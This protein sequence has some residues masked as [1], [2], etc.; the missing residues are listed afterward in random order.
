MRNT[1]AT[2]SLGAIKNN[3]AIV[4]KTCGETVAICAIIKADAYGHGMVKV[5]EALSLSG[6][7]KV[8]YFAVALVSEGVTLRDNGITLP[9][10]VLGSI[11]SSE[12]QIALENDLT[13]TAA[14]FEKLASIAEIGEKIGVIPTVH[15]KIDTGMGRVG[16]HYA[17]VEAFIA[18][19][20]SL[21]KEGKIHC[22]GMYSHFSDSLDEEFTKKQFDR[23]MQVVALAKE[24][25]LNPPLLH[26]CSSRS[27]FLY[28][29]YR[30]SMVRPGIVL[31][32]IEPEYDSSILPKEVI[33][34][35][36]LQTK[37]T[38]FKVV[39][40]GEFVGYGKSYT[41][42]ESRERII[43]LPLGYADGYPRRLSNRGRVLV[44]GKSYPVA[45]R[46][47]MDLFMVTLGEKGEAYVGDTV[48]LIGREGEEII[49]AQEIAKLIDAAPHEV[50]T[51]I[52]ARVPRVYEN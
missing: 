6:P 46:V 7:S 9:I 43:T 36:S 23:F 51:C 52:S 2:V 35:M 21:S 31:Y 3:A 14:S 12:I 16:V 39:D 27:I 38:Y 17:R 50:V 40:K 18:L 4:R 48:T 32:G 44:K 26:I 15:L 10:L 8:D 22:E 42:K 49:T 37:V 33:P 19:A 24:K 29:E 20:A 30:L 45:G 47:C 25:D 5:A 13:I 1:Y 34:A 28:P 11:D 41:P